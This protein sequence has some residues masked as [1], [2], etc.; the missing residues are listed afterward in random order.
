MDAKTDQECAKR[1]QQSLDPSL[2]HAKWQPQDNE[3]LMNA[4]KIHGRRWKVV[5]ET[6]FP[7]RSTTDLKN[8]YVDRAIQWRLSLITFAQNEDRLVD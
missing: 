3:K 2:I 4:V 8:R 7:G 1:W 6:T 5:A